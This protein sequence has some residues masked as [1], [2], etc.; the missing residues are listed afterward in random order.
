MDQSNS[1]KEIENEINKLREVIR[2][3]NYQYYVLDEPII[4]DH[5]YDKLLKRLMTLEQKYPEYISSDSPTQRVGAQPIEEF[6]TARHLVPMLSLSNAFS[7]KEVLDFDQR[8]KKNYSQQY[9]DYIVELK[10]DGLAIA[11]VYEDG[12]LQRGATRGNGFVGEDIT[13]NLRTINSIPLKLREYN[14]MNR[15]EVYGE[16]YMNRESF[17]KLNEE[18]NKKG[19]N[20]FAN[21]RNA[22]AGSVR[23]LDSS[24]TAKRQLD[25]FI[26]QAT[27]PEEHDFET[28]ME[29]LEFLKK[30]G[31][32]VNSNIK[33]F[34]NIEEAIDYCK[35]WKNKKNELN[36]EIDGMVI[37]VNQLD[38]RE[39]LGSTSRSP[40]WAIAYKFPAEQMTTVVEDIIVGVGRTGTLTPVAKL[41]PIVISGS[42]V[43]RAT[44]HNDDEI[45][46][47]D[48]RIGD[49]VLIQKA[50][51]VI[52]EIVKVIKEKRSGKEKIFNMPKKCP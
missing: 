7:E 23:Q 25:T 4:S 10:I 40:R 26:Y 18:R 29:V 46:R 38:L 2:K 28:H 33:Q 36:Y 35:S 24:I 43:Q 1:K 41:K 11:L 44:L 31:F 45:R 3:H 30:A 9:F 6:K 50:G 15:I 13:Q 27:F 14:H 17:K 22:A 20:L 49:T 5:E 19:E 8:I 21:P 16:V 47:K 52:P 51:E 48:I 12:I 39:R 32:K 34:D 37:K 42:R